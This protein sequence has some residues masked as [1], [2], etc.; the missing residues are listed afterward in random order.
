MTGEQR[1]LE[2]VIDI[3][4]RAVLVG[5]DLVDDHAPLG[6]DLPL[7]EGGLRCQFQQQADGLGKVLLEDGGMDD[8]LF[9]GRVG[10]QFAAE[11]V[12]IAGDGRGGPFPGPAEDRMLG[13]VGDALGE[14]PFVP[15]PAADAEG[16][17]AH[18]R[19]C[20]PN[21]VP[22]S[23]IRLSC[24]HFRIFLPRYRPLESRR[25]SCGRKPAP[26]LSEIRWRLK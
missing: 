13:E 23:F 16:A 21:G 25:R 18:G 1:L 15:G 6:L 22:E 19:P 5:D 8:D 20:L 4:G 3:L 17:I 9:L 12:Q 24:N 14:F 11:P 2:A 10:V 7:G 26:F